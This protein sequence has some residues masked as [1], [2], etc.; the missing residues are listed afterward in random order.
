MVNFPEFICFDH[1]FAIKVRKTNVFR[2]K[3]QMLVTQLESLR[4][5]CDRRTKRIDKIV[6]CIDFEGLATLHLGGQFTP[7]YGMLSSKNIVFLS[8]DY[9]VQFYPL[10]RS[11]NCQKSNF[12]QFTMSDLKTV[13]NL[14][15]L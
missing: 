2:L 7:A 8:L 13:G 11:K 12:S 3:I 4:L 5:L 10:L 1:I 6:S 14:R 15:L 9:F